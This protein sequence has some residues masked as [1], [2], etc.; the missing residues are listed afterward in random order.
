MEAIQALQE[1]TNQLIELLQQEEL[2][3]D[4]R[5]DKMQNLVQIGEKNY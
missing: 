2:E 3:R 1:V 4:E 5:I